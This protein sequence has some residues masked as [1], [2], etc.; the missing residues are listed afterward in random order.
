MENIDFDWLTVLLLLLL[1]LEAV[2]FIWFSKQAAPQCD[3]LNKWSAP[4]KQSTMVL[5]PADVSVISSDEAL[6]IKTPSCEENTGERVLPPVSTVKCANVPAPGEVTN[7]GVSASPVI[8]ID[9]VIELTEIDLMIE[10]A[11]HFAMHGRL[12]NAI[13]ILNDVV[14]RYPKRIEVWLLLLSIYRNKKDARHFESIAREFLKAVNCID[15]WKDIQEAGRSIDP[16]N[17]LYFD[18][19]S[20]F[21]IHSVQNIRQSKHRLLGEILIDMNAISA[22]VLGNCLMHYDRLR[23]GRLGN[24]LVALGL[25]KLVQLDEALQRQYVAIVGPSFQVNDACDSLINSDKPRWIGDVLMEMGA[26]T[27][28]ELDHVLVGFDTRCHGNY[29]QHLVTCG[30]I[31][32]KQLHA[33]LLRQLSGAMSAERSSEESTVEVAGDIPPDSMS[34]VIRLPAQYAE[35][36]SNTIDTAAL[37]LHHPHIAKKITLLWGYAE[38]RKLLVSLLSDS[39]D[40]MRAGF[41]EQNAKTLFAMLNQ[42]D[43]LFPQF[44]TSSDLWILES[45]SLHRAVNR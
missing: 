25:V 29:A 7:T 22:S 43:A 42:H 41:S 15:S 31:T 24:Y 39:R 45:A 17:N 8:Y 32:Q 35:K 4:P 18:A 5:I 37:F 30:L 16:D 6:S 38:C 9:D 27:E 12:H 36:K 11:E 14:R 33:A 3:P 40:R 26:V 2:W 21:A 19:D 28:P 10:E 34:N 20:M 23:D 44:D 1:L 13:E